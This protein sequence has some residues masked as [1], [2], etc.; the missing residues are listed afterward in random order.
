MPILLVESFF[1]VFQKSFLDKAS[2]S[3]LLY[4][5]S[6]FSIKFQTRV[7]IKLFSLVFSSNCSVSCSHKIVQSRVLIKL[8]SLVFS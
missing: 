6:S 2:D 5:C 4:I 1:I 8:F 7:L 3:A